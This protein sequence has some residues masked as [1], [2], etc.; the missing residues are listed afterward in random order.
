MRKESEIS[1]ISLDKDKDLLKKGTR[2]NSIFQKL[3]VLSNNQREEGKTPEI[4][5]H[6]EEIEE[7]QHIS[8]TSED[9]KKR[10]AHSVNVY[11]PNETGPDYDELLPSENQEAKS[12]PDLPKEAGKDEEALLKRYPTYTTESEVI[13]PLSAEKDEGSHYGEQEK[14][15][16]K[17]TIEL[18]P[19]VPEFVLSPHET[20][21]ESPGPII[22]D[23][24][25][26][27][28]V[29][30]E[31]HEDR[32]Y[33]AETIEGENDMFEHYDLDRGESKEVHEQHDSAREHEDTQFEQQ[34]ADQESV[35]S[36]ERKESSLKLSAKDLNRITSPLEF[37]E[38]LNSQG[39][40]AGR[41]V[42]NLRYEETLRA[43]QTEC[44]KLQR[45]VKRNN[46][47]V[48]II[49]EGMELSGKF[50][51]I[52]K[53]TKYMDP[54]A[55]RMV[56]LS[57][58]TQEEKQEWYF[59][60][61]TKHLPKPGEIVFFNRSWYD[62]GVLEPIHG[63]CTDE[64]YGHFLA[65]VPEFEYMLIENGY[66]VIKIWL[67]ISAK[68]QKG[69][70][71]AIA[72]DPLTNWKASP[73]DEGYL[74]RWS[75]AQKYRN[76]MFSWTDKNYSPWMIVS[77]KKRKQAR[78]ETMRHVLSTLDYDGKEDAAVSLKPDA[79]VVNR[80]HRSMITDDYSG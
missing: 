62:R 12:E 77:S 61:Y 6:G 55:I 78:L 38:S 20:E 80:F 23:T 10:E 74:E 17:E 54:R 15:E 65:Q 47:R 8:F 42:K 27:M 67:S 31:S 49:F 79:S 3:K 50:D 70:L 43:L 76:L 57:E 72:D 51:T 11:E 22:P 21:L 4:G 34:T 53:F 68:Q 39:V 18:S 7:E 14:V 69:R 73:F 2:I 36:K 29:D 44:V 13:V 35:E 37:V 30:A 66:K 75:N 48:V 60:R 33:S 71:N 41:F 58:R 45:S 5:S 64:E 59:Q 63:L 25:V 16:V 32:F 19:V 9:S 26:E 24:Y 28:I 46:E 52:R 1:S 40:K 56:S